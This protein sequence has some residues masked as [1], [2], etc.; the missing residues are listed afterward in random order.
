MLIADKLLSTSL[1]LFLSWQRWEIQVL[2]VKVLP[3]ISFHSLG[4]ANQHNSSARR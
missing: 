1:L 4:F 3:S 2:Y